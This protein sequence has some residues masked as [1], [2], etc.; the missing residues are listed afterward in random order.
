MDNLYVRSFFCF[1]SYSELTELKTVLEP[2]QQ[3]SIENT[4]VHQKYL[5]SIYDRKSLFF[6]FNLCPA[7]NRHVVPV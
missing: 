5:G 1:L 3:V 6:L 2:L 4:L 7:S